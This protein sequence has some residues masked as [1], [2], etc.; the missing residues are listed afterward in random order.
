MFK[1]KK[2]ENKIQYKS[3]T[4]NLSITADDWKESES[5]KLG[6]VDMYGTSGTPG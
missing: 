1:Q 5:N 2:F 6:K 4:V 3:E